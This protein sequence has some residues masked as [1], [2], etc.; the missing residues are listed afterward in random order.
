MR[1]AFYSQQGPAREVLRVG[2]QPTPVPGPGEVRVKLRASGV[3]PSD[4]KVRRGGFG[5]GLM[6]PLI[7]PHSDGAGDIDAVGPGVPD[8]VGERVWIWNGQWKRPHG[9]AAEYIVLPGAQAVR[10]PDG[11]DYASGACLGIPALTAIQAV[12]L[13]APGP[14]MTVLVAGGAGS[15]GHYAIQLA[16]LRGAKVIATI[17]SDLKAAHARKAGADEV[18]NYRS[19]DVGERVQVLTQGRGV[20]AVIEMDLTRNARY[21]PAILR[22]HATVAVYGMSA[23][24]TN[25]PSLWLMQNSITL[26]LFLVYDVSESDRA[27][28]IAEL[29]RL[30]EEG[31]L[32]HTVARRLRF[33]DVAEAHDAVERGELIGNAR[34]RLKARR[35]LYRRSL[36][37]SRIPVPQ[38]ESHHDRHRG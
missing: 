20:D 22:P 25:L 32:A 8:R 16:K 2:E 5:R 30:L 28:G 6:A 29:T 18:I 23:G 27:A 35:P 24:E 4:W 1:A 31:R 17:S 34:H 26:R 10:L 9:T 19:E 12:R 38:K 15:V 37:P 14:G 33:E 21:Y 7:I 36:V 13:A 11:V 3:N